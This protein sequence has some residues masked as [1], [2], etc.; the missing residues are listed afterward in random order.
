MG[1]EV[2][3]VGIHNNTSFTQSSM[4]TGWVFIGWG[5]ATVLVQQY[6]EQL[7]MQ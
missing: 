6:I 1:Q 4:L 5:P 3:T 2:L 7:S